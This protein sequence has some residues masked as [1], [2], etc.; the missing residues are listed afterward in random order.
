VTSNGDGEHGDLMSIDANSLGVVLGSAMPPEQMLP[1]AMEADRCGLDELWFTEDCFF[2]GGISGAAAALAATPRIQVGLGV[3][4]AM[5]RHPALLSMEIA[6]MARAFPGRVVAGIGLGVPAWLRQVGLL[7]SSSLGAM[8]E[9]V[10]AI[11]QLLAGE[12]LDVA[13]DQ[14]AFADVAL[15]HP[16]AGHLPICLGVCGPRMLRLSGEIADGTILSAG[17]GVRYVNWARK[18]IDGGRAMAGRADAHRVTMFALYAVGQDRLQ[19]REEMREPLARF[20]AA[21]GIDAITEAEGI[22]DAL[23]PMLRRGGPDLVA[24]EIPDSW[25]DQLSVCGTPED[26]ARRIGE[27]YAAGA[28]SVALFPVTAGQ[29]QDMVRVTAQQVRPLL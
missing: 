7:P 6:T 25:I 17:A 16:V 20:L 19:A 14:F 9:C 18:Q 10:T 28:D 27:F 15:A 12:R 5:L 1:A 11:R 13:G 29:P 8:T 21:G 22:S 3:V 24:R 2:T 23:A 26:C 4:S